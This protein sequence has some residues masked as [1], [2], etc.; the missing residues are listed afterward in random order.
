MRIGYPALR[1]QERPRF[2]YVPV[3]YARQLLLE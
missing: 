1:Q 2:F 3:E